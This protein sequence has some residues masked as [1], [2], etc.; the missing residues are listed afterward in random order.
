V[1]EALEASFSETAEPAFLFAQFFSPR[2]N[3]AE[4]DSAGLRL[5]LHFAKIVLLAG[6]AIFL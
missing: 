2:T 6:E 5:W 4:R 1:R 3:P